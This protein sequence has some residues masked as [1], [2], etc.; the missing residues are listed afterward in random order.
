MTARGDHGTAVPGRWS[1][2]G[3]SATGPGH[4]RLGLHNQDAWGESEIRPGVHLV[5]VADGAGSRSRSER[6]SMLA[7]QAAHGAAAE[8][9]GT[10]TP[11]SPGDW[12][13]ALGRFEAECL[14]RFDRLL[15][16]MLAEGPPYLA[17][18]G[19]PQPGDYATTL[20][21]AVVCGPWLAYVGVGD[22]FLVV[23]RDDDS[24]H[25]V[26]GE[27]M[28]REQQG[29]TVFMTSQNRAANVERGLLHDPALAGIALCTDGLAEPMLATE[30]GAAHGSWVMTAPESFAAFFAFAA[31]G[32]DPT[33]LTRRFQDDDFAAASP[34]DK[35][36]VLAV[37]NR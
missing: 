4:L 6:G 2:I 19:D 17:G 15:K 25:L 11:S 5:V 7:V 29:A 20:L 32:T 12:Q 31:Q 14:R 18:Q 26:L 33:A 1:V 13:H 16:A 24:A 9:F 10:K 21:A 3:A 36:M 30:A 22:C 37:R 23:W 28:D 34:D 35:T 27:R 8:V